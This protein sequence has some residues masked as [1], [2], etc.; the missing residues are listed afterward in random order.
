MDIALSHIDTL[1]LSISMSDTSCPFP[2]DNMDTLEV[3][4]LGV[5]I[6]PAMV[7]VMGLLPDSTRRNF[8]TKQVLPST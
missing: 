4:V 8:N 2:M 3:K 6:I 5:N 7:K 1:T